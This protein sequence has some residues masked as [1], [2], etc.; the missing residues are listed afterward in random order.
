MPTV[1]IVG[2]ITYHHKC[3]TVVRIL[4]NFEKSSV[5]TVV[6]PNHEHVSLKALY[7]KRKTSSDNLKN[8][9]VSSSKDRDFCNIRQYSQ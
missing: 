1:P 7:L 8:K 9:H 5:S 4:F 3:I 6:D 2:Y